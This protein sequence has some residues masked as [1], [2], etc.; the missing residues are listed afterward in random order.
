MVAT[1]RGTNETATFEDFFRGEYPRL[2]RM[3]R[4]VCGDH[5]SAE[6]VGQEA[7]SK[8]HAEWNRIAAYDSP[9]AWV[10]RV[11]LNRVSNLRRSRHREA[12][13]I[14]RL[15]PTDRANV[16]EIFDGD[17]WRAVAALPKQQRW[18]VVLFYVAD[19]A[20]VDVAAVLECSEGSVKTHLS[21]ARQTLA[22]SLRFPEETE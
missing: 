19:A 10:R 21:R 3:L 8:A 5:Q 4:A 22:R 2:V 17:L 11:T 18:A 14:H 15:A 1:H 12:T 13:A 9:T 20:I 16:V 7:L 6:D